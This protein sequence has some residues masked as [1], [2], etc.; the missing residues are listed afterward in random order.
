MVSVDVCASL[1]STGKGDVPYEMNKVVVNPPIQRG[2]EF[3]STGEGYESVLTRL[4]MTQS[5]FLSGNRL[6]DF[7]PVGAR[8]DDKVRDPCT[9]NPRSLTVFPFV[10]GRYVS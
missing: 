5:R 7:S 8:R 9:R 1:I 2:E 4:T 10:G 6:V 3:R